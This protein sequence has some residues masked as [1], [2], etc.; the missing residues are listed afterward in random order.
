M[1]T[2]WDLLIVSPRLETK[3]Q[4][5]GI[6]KGLPVSTFTAST[7]A[8]AREALASHYFQLIFSEEN[9]ADGSYRDLLN[10]IHVSNLKTS[11]VLM[12]C[13]GEWEEYLEGLR[14]GADEVIRCPLQPTDVELSLIRASR[15]EEP[16]PNTRRS[17]KVWELHSRIH[18]SQHRIGFRGPAKW[19]N[20]NQK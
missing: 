15:R 6:L 20:L 19:L 9:F 7:V 2:E 16:S 17:A 5:L 18:R 14:S 4:L 12:L 10:L 11:L 3:R 13:T 1:T 8:Q